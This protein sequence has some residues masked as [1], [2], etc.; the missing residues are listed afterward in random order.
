MSAEPTSPPLPPR[1]HLG[2]PP[3]HRNTSNSQQEKEVPPVPHSDNKNLEN[4]SIRIQADDSLSFI[5]AVRQSEIFNSPGMNETFTGLVNDSSFHQ[6]LVIPDLDETLNDQD[7]VQFWNE[8]IWDYSNQWIRRREVDK[9]ETEILKGI[10]SDYRSIVYL[11]TL[12]VRYK[13]N[14]DV[15]FAEL[16]KRSSKFN[17][18]IS[19]HSD[20]QEVVELV[21]VIL[22]LVEEPELNA[23]SA[24]V[25]TLER[26]LVSLAELLTTI[27]GLSEERR[28]FVLI[29]L[30]KLYSLVKSEEFIYKINRS[31]E[32]KSESFKHVASQGINLSGYYKRLIPELFFGKFDLEVSL[33]ILDLFVFEGFDFLLR[34]ISWA[35]LQSDAKLAPL[36][37]DDLLTFLESKDFF[38][39]FNLDLQKVLQLQPPLITYENEYYL[40]EA[41]S[42]SNNK[43]ELRNLSEVHDDLLLKINNM[44]VQ[45]EQL[46][47]THTE[48]SQ[49]SEEYNIDLTEA[50]VKR[51]ALLEE[52]ERLQK[53][54]EH[55]T[56]KENLANTIKANEEFSQ[57]NVELQQ[58]L[59]ALKKSIEEKK[60]KIAKA[61]VNNQ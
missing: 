12:Q 21:S 53:R 20:K 7:S 2:S 25:A 4:A 33:K 29:K 31:L 57:R 46:Q 48:I 45:I 14:Q 30:Y 42:L 24:N 34:L 11:K 55:L 10:P 8:I 35:F 9:L 19:K 18:G 58:Q 26:Y 61:M 38:S 56:M 16:L 5:S 13:W 27:P 23:R 15:S 43:N 44:K 17:N 40:M 1:P 36:S 22:L 59:E 3:E 39:D 49:Q 60:H 52:K 51:K 28:L 50:E 6:H 41:N 37:G 54:Y 47:S 32:D